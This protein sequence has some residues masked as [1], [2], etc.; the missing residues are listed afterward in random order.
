MLCCKAL[1]AFAFTIAS[2]AASATPTITSR[3]FK[4][5]N[6][7]PE[8]LTSLLNGIQLEPQVEKRYLTNAYRLAAGLPLNPPVRR[9]QRRRSA[10]HH[11]HHPKPSSTPQPQ[12]KRGFVEMLDAD[13]GSPVGFVSKNFNLVGQ[14]TVTEDR[15][16]ALGVQIDTAAAAN[17]FVSM[18]SVNGPDSSHPF[19]GA[20]GGWTSAS[21]DLGPGSPEVI[22]YA[23]LGAVLE[24]LAHSTP[25]VAG[26]SFTTLTQIKEPIESAIWS[27]SDDGTLSARWV[28]TD[29]SR[30]QVFAG[31]I[32]NTLIL[33][34][35]KAAFRDSFAYP[36]QFVNFQFVVAT[37]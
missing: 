36:T 13:N 21:D 32:E 5:I 23:T 37:S 15:S 18:Q 25:Q 2:V 10:A 22:G 3:T 24:T 1:A 30:P 28:N 16:E 27:L 12:L 34:G 29:G 31:V 4:S 20:I 26:N 35:D 11:A 33:T 7:P 14:Y 6:P 8:L 17:G 19:F 9:D